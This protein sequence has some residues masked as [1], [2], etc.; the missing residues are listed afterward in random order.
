[1]RMFSPEAA[2][3]AIELQQMVYDFKRD[4]DLNG[5][6]N[7]TEFFTEDCVVQV[8]A[9]AF[10]RHDGVKQYYADRAEM[11]RTQQRD[12]VRTT[13]HG[14]LNIQISF[15]TPDRATLNCLIVT[16][17]GSGKAPIFECTAPVSI[18][19]A[20]FECRRDD[21]GQ[22]RIFGFY[23]GVVFVGNETFARKAILGR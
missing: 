12:G 4:I 11:I 10:E 2:V 19:D 8:A 23:G 20:R 3:A 14:I 6:G 18:S 9:I 5:G 15:E 7:A 1:L 22:W 21:Q 17:A 16:F 13:R